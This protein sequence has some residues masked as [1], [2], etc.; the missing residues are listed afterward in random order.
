MRGRTS[1]SWLT[2]ARLQRSRG[3]L[4][5]GGPRPLRRRTGRSGS[6]SS[7][8]SEYAARAAR[9]HRHRY[10]RSGHQ[11]RDGAGRG[12]LRTHRI[13]PPT[14]LV[15]LVHQRQ[16][17]A[18]LLRDETQGQRLEASGTRDHE[19][20]T[21]RLDQES[22]RASFAEQRQP[23]HVSCSSASGPE[24][25][26]VPGIPTIPVGGVTGV[27][28]DTGCSPYAGIPDRPALR[29]IGCNGCNGLGIERRQ[30]PGPSVSQVGSE[31]SALD[32]IPLSAR[33]SGRVRTVSGAGPR[34][35][36]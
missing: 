30:I 20:V 8:S 7:G 34:A 19:V 10:A 1:A 35:W 18:T 14:D 32:D 15:L 4:R 31:V 29:C 12:Q 13:R 21:P 24:P 16:Q 6:V 2:S 26:G 33:A 3:L 27:T 23:V 17:D 36:G 22:R 28:G 5:R 11:E 9:A 25:V